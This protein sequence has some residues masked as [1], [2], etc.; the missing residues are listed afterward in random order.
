MPFADQD[1]LERNLSDADQDRLRIVEPTITRTLDTARLQHHQLNLL[2]AEGIDR[3][4]ERALEQ[5]VTERG[6][7]LTTE[8]SSVA[9]AP[10]AHLELGEVN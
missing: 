4:N 7:P 1:R 5:P 10:A 2:K 9:D 8:E 6:P 3:T